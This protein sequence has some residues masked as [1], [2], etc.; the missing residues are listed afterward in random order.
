MIGIIY[1][2]EYVVEEEFQL[3]KIPCEW[4]DSSNDVV[5]ACKA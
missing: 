4:Y 5:I 1:P 2:D 3:L